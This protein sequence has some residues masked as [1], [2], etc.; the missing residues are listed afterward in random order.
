MASPLVSGIRPL[1]TGKERD[2]ESGLDYFGARYYGLSMGRFMS[3]DPGWFQQA[4][5]SNPQTWNQYTY[6]LNSPLINTDP[7]GRTCQTNS[8]DGTVYDNNDG[9]GC[10]TVDEADKKAAPSAT[11]NADG[12]Y[13]LVTE[14]GNAQ[15]NQYVTNWLRSQ[16]PQFPVAITT[17]DPDKRRIQE[18]AKRIAD[19]T[20]VI[21]GGGA[22]IYGGPEHEGGVNG[23][24][25]NGGGGGFF[26]VDSRD[27]MSG[28]VIGNAGGSRGG[29]G[30]VY[31]SEKEGFVFI[32]GGAGVVVGASKNGV[33]VGEY[34]G[35]EGK[36]V[37]D[38]AYVNLTTAS[39]CPAR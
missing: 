4:D 33:S 30:G 25:V 8:S 19:M 14:S 29:V 6:D 26:N 9:K 11:V 31:G 24:E 39:N 34:V 18:L 1:Y 13:D 23:H 10:A 27:G 5:P 15:T 20:P 21:C 16:G 7:T 17:S 22:F 35:L 38:G 36:Y 3:P 12:H 37:G 32:G 2:T 28:G